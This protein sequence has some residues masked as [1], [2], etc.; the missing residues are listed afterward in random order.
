M[1]Q[2]ACVEN[3]KYSTRRREEW[4]LGGEKEQRQGRRGWPPSLL[5]VFL[6]FFCSTW[7]G[8][9][10]G[11]MEGGGEG[12]RGREREALARWTEGCRRTLH[13]ATTAK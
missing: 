13:L 3:G 7:R 8:D 11:R 10:R 6:R 5:A 9:V 1:V 4:W 2:E 12:G